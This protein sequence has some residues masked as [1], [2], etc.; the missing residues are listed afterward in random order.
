MVRRVQDS[1]ILDLDTPCRRRTCSVFLLS[2]TWTPAWPTLVLH[3]KCP[4]V[5]TDICF[6]FNELNSEGKN[7]T[8][9]KDRLLSATCTTD[10]VFGHCLGLWIS[11]IYIATSLETRT[12]QPRRNVYTCKTPHVDFVPCGLMSSNPTVNFQILH[13]I[14]FLAMWEEFFFSFS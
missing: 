4:P 2:I 12:T 8:G 6:C 9:R 11:C 5:W 1:P 7:K 14:S 3:T 13:H 10:S